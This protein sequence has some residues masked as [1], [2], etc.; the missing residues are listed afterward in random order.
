MTLKVFAYDA[1]AL[2]N[3]EDA[4][5]FMVTGKIGTMPDG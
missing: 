3:Q 2:R 1:I 4:V 5:R